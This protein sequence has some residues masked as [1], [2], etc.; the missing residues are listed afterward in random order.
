MPNAYAGVL[1]FC[2][3][4]ILV[5]TILTVA[6]SIGLLLAT[7]PYWYYIAINPDEPLNLAFFIISAVT[8]IILCFL[9]IYG[10]IKKNKA[11]LLYFA[12][13]MLV[14][15]TVTFTQITL[16]LIALSNCNDSG[17]PFHFMC[18]INE[19]VY[20]AHSTVVVLI[21]LMCSVCAFLLRHRLRKQEQDPDNVY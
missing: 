14:M 9:G 21:G 6:S 13:I 8:L 20:F 19:I 12:I 5:W 7:A 2:T 16:T 1:D 3:C 11:V 15:I 10:A 18:D 17:S 4:D